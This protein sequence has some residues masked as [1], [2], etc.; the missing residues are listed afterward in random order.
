MKYEVEL[1]CRPKNCLFWYK[2]FETVEAD[3][4]EHA[5]EVAMATDYGMEIDLEKAI[6]IPKA[7]APN[8]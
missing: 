4:P 3:S 2:A 6:A 8:N 1:Y 7:D 5:I